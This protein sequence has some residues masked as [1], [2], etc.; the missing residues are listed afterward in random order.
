MLPNGGL[1]LL[2][3]AAVASG[4]TIRGAL[5]AQASAGVHQGGEWIYRVAKSTPCFSHTNHVEGR[6]GCG[7][8]GKEKNRREA[9]SKTNIL[10]IINEETQEH[11]LCTSVSFS[12]EG[13]AKLNGL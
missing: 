3:G 6:W 11:S 8:R 7:W 4:W 1:L 9:K 12:G 10:E 2:L 13:K 5:L